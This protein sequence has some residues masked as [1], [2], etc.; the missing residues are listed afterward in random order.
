MLQKLY[1]Q[2]TSVMYSTM[3]V[4]TFYIKLEI[5]QKQRKIHYYRIRA[6]RSIAIT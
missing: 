1:Q 5:N 6:Q 4:V 3:T 2:L